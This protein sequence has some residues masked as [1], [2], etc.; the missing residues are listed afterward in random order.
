MRWPR[1][2]AGAGQAPVPRSGIEETISKRNRVM[3]ARGWMKTRGSMRKAL[4]PSRQGARVL[5]ISSI[6]Y[7]LEFPIG[8]RIR[9]GR[10]PMSYSPWTSGVLRKIRAA[11]LAT[12]AVSRPFLLTICGALA[13][14]SC[15][16]TYAVW[17]HTISRNQFAELDSS[18]PRITCITKRL[19]P[20]TEASEVRIV[21]RKGYAL[22]EDDQV[23]GGP[24]RFSHDR[25]S[26]TVLAEIVLSRRSP[27]YAG[28][29]DQMHAIAAE[30]G[31]DALI[32]VGYSLGIGDRY[33]GGFLI[34]GWV[35]HGLA[36]VSKPDSER[37]LEEDEWDEY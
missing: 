32:D 16:S 17:P 6:R 10:N 33:Y 21:Y 35:Y 12:S 4:V 15:G 22:T 18:L 8:G 20:P 36:I 34:E 30:L 14:G 31:A 13:V 3:A 19:N 7:Q 1:E 28:A 24:W 37:H 26:V 11:C 9:V 2:D 25:F 23:G 27:D 5:I 29:V